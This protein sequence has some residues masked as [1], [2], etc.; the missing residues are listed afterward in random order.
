[1]QIIEF[2]KKGKVQFNL[3]KIV[4]YKKNLPKKIEIIGFL[5]PSTAQIT[6]EKFLLNEKVLQAKKTKEYENKFQNR[7]ITN[8]LANIFNQN[9]INKYFKN[10]L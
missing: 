2:G 3:T 9:K 8:S 7:V 5:I 1:V 4:K 6:F 10:L